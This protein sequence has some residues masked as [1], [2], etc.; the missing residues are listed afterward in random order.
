MSV[1]GPIA[2]FFFVPN[3]QLVVSLPNDQLGCFQEFE[4]YQRSCLSVCRQ[5]FARAFLLMGEIADAQLLRMRGVC[6]SW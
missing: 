4:V 1:R 6:P 5:S 3:H 2:H